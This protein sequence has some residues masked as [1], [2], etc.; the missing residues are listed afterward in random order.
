MSSS[1]IEL[2]HDDVDEPAYWHEARHPLVSLVFLIP[3]LA[4]YEFG[5][6]V[7]AAATPGTIRNGADHWMRGL[8]HAWGF[9]HGQLLP[10]L[11][12]GGLLIWHVAGKY[13]WRLSADTLLGM[14]AESVLFA[15][16]LII[17]G[18]LQDLAFRQLNLPTLNLPEL[19]LGP[20]ARRAITFIGAGVYEE[21]LFRLCLLPAVYLGFRWVGLT[22]S[23]GILLAVLSTGLA[24]SA[25]HHI[26]TGGEPFRLFVFMFRTMAGLFFA[27]LFYLRGFGIT[28]GCHAAYDLMVGVVLYDPV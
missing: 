13:P 6:F 22:G 1:A 24:F 27:T 4:I 2:F 21:F 25:A 19:N 16:V 9:G 7:H 12:I 3:L 5:V 20:M 11:V 26:G 10:A 18:Q 28:V 17:A 14:L 8:L 15:F 23:T